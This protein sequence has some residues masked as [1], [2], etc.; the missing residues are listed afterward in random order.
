MKFKL[1]GESDEEVLVFALK[2][3]K[4]NGCMELLINNSV[5]CFFDEERFAIEN[6]KLEEFGFSRDVKTY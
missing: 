2:N 1:K 5:I 3:N 4:D 6:D